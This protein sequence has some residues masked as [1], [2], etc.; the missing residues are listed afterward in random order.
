MTRREAAT[1]VAALIYYDRYPVRV[2]TDVKVPPVFQGTTPLSRD[3]V[4]AL[5]VRLE[6][7]EGQDEGA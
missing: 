3:E 4:S 1:V 6:A 2:L 5:L 7:G